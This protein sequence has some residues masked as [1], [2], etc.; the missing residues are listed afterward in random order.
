MKYKISRTLFFGLLTLGAFLI[1]FWSVKN[2]YTDKLSSIA[3]GAFTAL[4]VG[5]LIELVIAYRKTKHQAAE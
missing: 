4:F 2:S 1:S 3:F 5:C